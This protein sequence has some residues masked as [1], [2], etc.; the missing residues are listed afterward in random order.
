MRLCAGQIGFEIAK[1][2]HELQTKQNCR[3]AAKMAT[4][5]EDDDKNPREGADAERFCHHISTILPRANT[6]IWDN[7]FSRIIEPRFAG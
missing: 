3:F 2:Y 6:L 5:A 7:A 4:N 1:I